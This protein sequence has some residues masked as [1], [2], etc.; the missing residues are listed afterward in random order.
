MKLNKTLFTR[1]TNR[2]VGCAPDRWI[3]QIDRSIPFDTWQIMPDPIEKANVQRRCD[4][5]RRREWRRCIRFDPIRIVHTHTQ[6]TRS[7]SWLARCR[8]LWWQKWLYCLYVLFKIMVIATHKIVSCYIHAALARLTIS[9]QHK[10]QLFRFIFEWQSLCYGLMQLSLTL[11][12][13]KSQ[14]LQTTN[15]NCALKTGRLYSVKVCN[16]CVWREAGKGWMICTVCSCGEANFL[17]K[18]V[19]KREQ[20]AL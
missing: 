17:L 12:N 10:Y 1:F 9:S 2:F 8:W 7:A 16:N 19:K 20:R 14:Q 3:F 13:H 6:K 4:W 18:R 11:T 5:E 15:I